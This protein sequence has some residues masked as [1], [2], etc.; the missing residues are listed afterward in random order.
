MD[1]R[2]L[3]RNGVT[4]DHPRASCRIRLNRLSPSN[5]E[6]V[7]P[8]RAGGAAQR[9]AVRSSAL[10]MRV[11]ILSD[12]HIEF[13]GNRIPALAPDAELVILAGDLA[14]VCTHRVGEIAARWAAADN[15]LY[16]PGNH[17]YYGSD[18][19]VAR[20]ELARQCLQ[21][22]VTLLDPGAVTVEH[23]RFIA[24]T[25]W[26]DFLLEGNVESRYSV[27]ETTGMAG[28]SRC[29][30]LDER[31]GYSQ[32]ARVGRGT[33]ST[34]DDSVAA[35]VASASSPAPP[36]VGTLGPGRRHQYTGAARRQ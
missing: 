31:F 26:T 36:P 22:G 19:D 17:E 24:A 34:T 1:T 11:Q 16:V 5:L 7:R 33:K 32:Q 2:R 8:V 12:L 13:P 21:R 6:R 10:V 27:D 20:H 18:I 35:Y 14:P 23:L 15:I 28:S 3:H 25:L 29:R 4:V 30:R 9:K